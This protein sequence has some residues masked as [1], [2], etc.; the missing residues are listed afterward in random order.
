MELTEKLDNDWKTIQGLLSHKTPKSERKVE[1]EKP[2]VRLLPGLYRVRT[3]GED[4]NE[5]CAFTVSDNVGPVDME[6]ACSAR[7]T[8]KQFRASS[9][10]YNIYLF[11][12]VSC[13]PILPP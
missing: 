4:F 7:V 11:Y 8:F 6:G 5:V 2:K 12:N 10:K 1:P 13:L 9:Y 3:S